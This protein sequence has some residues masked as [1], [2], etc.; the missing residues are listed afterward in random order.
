MIWIII[1]ISDHPFPPLG[2]SRISAIFVRSGLY[3]RTHQLHLEVPQDHSDQRRN[4]QRRLRHSGV[5]HVGIAA[6]S[7]S[8]SNGLF[9]EGRI[10]P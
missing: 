2:S 10:R 8:K 7:P 1:W 3:E 6:L 5:G 9:P 4:A